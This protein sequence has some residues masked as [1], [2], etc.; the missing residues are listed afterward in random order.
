MIGLKNLKKINCA[1]LSIVLTLS[2]MTSY[3][4]NIKKG[5]F[6]MC[7]TLYVFVCIYYVYIYTHNIYIGLKL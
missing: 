1:L 4:Q 5:K 2:S 7:I 3:T 6:H